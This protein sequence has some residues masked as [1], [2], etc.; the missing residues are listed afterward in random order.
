MFPYV[1]SHLC[2][3]GSPGLLKRHFRVVLPGFEQSPM[4]AI[5]LIDMLEAAAYALV[6]ERCRASYL[7][8]VRGGLQALHSAVELL[9]RAAN[10]PA[11]QPA[12]TE[13]ATSFARRAVQ[14]QEQ[15]LVELVDQMTPQREAAST[16]N[17][18]ELIGDV[19]RF[20]KND[21][22]S[23]SVALHLESVGD[24]LVCAQPHKL[25]LLILGL[26]L[27]L[28]DRIAPGSVIEMEVARSGADG[29]IEFRSIPPCS[30][31]NP[32]DLW[33]PADNMSSACELLL[34]I[35]QHW[36]AANGGRLE[37]SHEPHLPN[38]L[39]IYYPLA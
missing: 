14:R 4:N 19:V 38:A 8:D 25:R 21:L 37:L 5:S 10:S 35:T 33:R 28:C 29:L 11:N 17:V 36:A 2:R 32:Q 3:T 27:T 6:N 16:I 18:G 9:A 23:K 30:V 12:L 34:S 15:L 22:S 13:K 31:V 1:T 20:I 26:C 24:V 39:R 7:H